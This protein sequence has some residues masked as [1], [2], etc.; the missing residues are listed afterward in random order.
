MST[1][2]NI[3]VAPVFWGLGHATR[4]IPII[5]QLQNFNYNVIL[6]SDGAA[7][8]L[9]RKEF[10]TLDYIQLPGYNIRYP[11]KG[12]FFKLK[13]ISQLSPILKTIKKEHK[14][15]NAMLPEKNIH[16]I[17]SD[18]RLGLSS[19]KVPSVYITH[20]LQLHTGKTT[21][22][23][24]W[25]HRKL[26][27]KFDAVWIPDFINPVAG[28][29]GK[30]GHPKKLP[31]N[32]KY[33]EPL[34]RFNKK[35]LP[36]TIDY[37]IVLSGPEPQRSMLEEVLIKELQNSDKKIVLV[38]GKIEEKQK[39]EKIGV[40]DVVNYMHSDELE[41]VLNQCEYVISRSGYSTIMDLARLEKK[42]FFIP[43][44]GQYEQLYLSKRLRYL[45]L[46]YSCQQNEFKADKLKNLAVYKGLNA[47][48]EKVDFENLFQIFN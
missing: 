35:E 42:A 11:K 5:K 16:G 8:E 46:V 14:I 10:P 17:I 45:G 30:L 9:L 31:H 12:Y 43:T 13:L 37:L 2:K 32:A 36:K 40:I 4:C 24:S 41:Q 33:I 29:S 48:V 44:P 20:Q 38:Q 18:G 1:Q 21:F 27:E 28:L 22:I 34:S 3:L 15:L 23:S 26:M 6:A 7:L 19:A 25:Y 47:P 39:R